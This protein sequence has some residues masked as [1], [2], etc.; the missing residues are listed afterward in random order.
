C[1][2][3]IA[4]ASDTV[5]EGNSTI[6]TATVT[7]V[8]GGSVNNVIFTSSNSTIASVCASGA[9]PCGGAAS[10]T[11]STSP[12]T[13]GATG[14]ASGN[15]TLSAQVT[16]GG[17]SGTCSDTSSLTVGSVPTP[18]RTPTP[19]PPTP[20]V[21]PTP[22]ADTPT[23]TP[24]P[25][26]PTRTPTPAP[27]SCNVVLTVNSNP[28]AVAGST[29]GTANV[30]LTNGTSVDSVLFTSADAS[31]ASIC[32]PAATPCPAG[33]SSRNDT[34]APY[35]L[36][37]TGNSSGN[38]N[39]TAQVTVDGVAD[40][41]SDSVTMTVGA[42]DTP[43]PTPVADTPTPTPGGNCVAAD[44]TWQNENF[45]NQTGVF[46]AEFDVIPNGGNVD[47]GDIGLSDGPAGGVNDLAANVRFNLG[48]NIR[49]YDGATSSFA[50][51]ISYS[52]GVNYHLRMEL[53]INTDTYDV[54]V[55]PDGSPELTLSTGLLFRNPVAQLNNQAIKMASTA[56]GIID[57]CDFQSFTQGPWFKIK[58]GSFSKIGSFAMRIPAVVNKFDADDTT[59][60]YLVVN[61]TNDPGV[62]VIPNPPATDQASS[63]EWINSSNYTYKTPFTPETFL[64][65]IKS[66][67]EYRTITNLSNL[68]SGIYQYNNNLTINNTS[69]YQITGASPVS[70]FVAGGDVTINTTDNVFGNSASPESVVIFTTGTINIAPNMQELNGLF[71]AN[72]VNFGTSNTPLKIVGNIISFGPVD[73]TTRDR[74]DLSR[75]SVFIVVKPGMY[76]DL[77]PIFSTASYEWKQLQ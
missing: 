10:Y 4:P 53:N 6:F 46:T 15:I 52:A 36:G 51:S 57:V 16:V 43:T 47:Q 1:T 31:I 18:T 74:A 19:I 55:T 50:G 62:V 44:S 12:Y 30:N 23:P 5:T 14:K 67:K 24:I 3:N 45:A 63:K 40:V 72:Q 42:A 68:S 65:Y 73:S 60:P 48:G 75:P 17:V 49:A 28:I 11:D 33:N 7:N 2:V 32:G 37:I 66:R 54:F 25:P 59:Q 71:I 70:L 58:D 39:I 64:S 22:A 76:L 26:T 9:I 77:L 29:Q 27:Q 8:V 21:T 35:S 38:V 69:E 41:C 13:V 34:S 61:T 56:S 20:T